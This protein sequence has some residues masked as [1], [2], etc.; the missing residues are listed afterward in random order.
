MLH[1]V[2]R[3]N[4]TQKVKFTSYP[5]FETL[6]WAITYYHGSQDN[7]KFYRDCPSVY[8][9]YLCCDEDGNEPDNLE[10]MEWD[11]IEEF[12]LDNITYLRFEVNGEKY[13]TSK[14]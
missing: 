6:S 10:S 14:E 3:M 13:W 5:V 8:L 2:L 12:M 1:N 11:A 7:E 4:T 9:S